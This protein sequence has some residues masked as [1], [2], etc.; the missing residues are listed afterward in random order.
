MSDHSFWP[1]IAST[2]ITIFVF[3]IGY[4]YFVDKRNIKGRTN[5]TDDLLLVIFLGTSLYFSWYFLLASQGIVFSLLSFSWL[6]EFVVYFYAILALFFPLLILYYLKSDNK[7]KQEAF[8]KFLIKF[9][10]IIIPCVFS[11]LFLCAISFFIFDIPKIAKK[12]VLPLPTASVVQDMPDSNQAVY[13][14]TI[15][16]NFFPRTRPM[17]ETGEFW[18]RV[19]IPIAGGI[20]ATIALF[21]TYKRTYAMDRQTDTMIQ[22]IDISEQEVSSEQF[23]NA[24]DQLGESK[25]AVILG[26]VHTL[27]SIAQYH[28]NRYAKTVFDILCS[29]I[30]QAATSHGLPL[31]SSF[32]DDLHKNTYNKTT[33]SHTVIDSIL[34]IIFDNNKENKDGVNKDG[35]FKNLIVDFNGAFLNRC[36]HLRFSNLKKAKLKRINLAHTSLFHADLSEA[37][38]SEANLEYCDLSRANLSGAILIGAK[39]VGANLSGAD[40]TG[41]NLSGADLTG[42]NLSDSNL[43]DSALSKANASYADDT[44][45]CKTKKTNLTNADFTEADLR[46]A[47]LVNAIL[48]KT[49][50][51]RTHLEEADLSGITFEDTAL[52]G[53]YLNK[54]NLTGAILDGITFNKTNLIEVNLCNST[55]TNINFNRTNLS[56][57]NFSGATIERSML[58]EA[59]LINACFIGA[60]IKNIA[61]KHAKLENANFK[62]ADISESNFVGAQMK[63]VIFENATLCHTTFN[64]AY[65]TGANFRSATCKGQVI[66]SWTKLDDAI[67]SN[68]DLAGVNM[69]NASLKKAAL[70]DAN[71]SGAI[72]SQSQMRGAILKY[73]TMTGT[74]LEEVILEGANIA[75]ANLEGADLRNSHLEGALIKNIRFSESTL[76]KG[77]VFSGVQSKYYSDIYIDTNKDC[78]TE[79]K[80]CKKY[81]KTD[82]TGIIRSKS[83]DASE[84]DIT[85]F[86]GDDISQW[87]CD[88]GAITEPLGLVEAMKIY[89][90]WS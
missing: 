67:F 86:S 35:V 4:Q 25:Q 87:L 59:C 11:L 48:T 7:Q 70:I 62:D 65:L 24:I 28:E 84:I 18:S 16:E 22:R 75:G 23:K 43:A 69:A 42:A 14:K 46:N 47:V 6:P 19:M 66:F 38:L 50:F 56:R 44:D 76:I 51:I 53:A 88:S 33:I 74:D 63:G 82:L 61:L 71:L 89:E 73:A 32:N 55:I 30:R 3:V 12:I 45:K 52:D 72:L 1:Y 27:F 40:L 20:I 13:N 68:A 83:T 17:T 81:L 15:S 8:A 64:R 26:G 2:A 60:T 36:E 31:T 10:S 21:F 9:R 85:T 58:E 34:K 57:A 90:L 78:I 37:D 5:T 77:A 39:L 54:A 80:S 79:D 41:A 29:Y 49:K